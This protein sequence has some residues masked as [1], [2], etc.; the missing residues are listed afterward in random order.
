MGCSCPLTGE[1]PG[2]L[3]V[4][5]ATSTIREISACLF[6]PY[7]SAD[8]LHLGRMIV[9]T[10]VLYIDTPET[11]SEMVI[12]KVGSHR[13]HLLGLVDGLDVRGE[14]FPNLANSNS[15]LLMESSMNL[16]AAIG[17]KSRE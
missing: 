11:L 3:Q 10:R 6:L 5:A 12:G 15:R 9:S 8:I 7:P 2:A 13:L 17:C 16:F 1:Q 14:P 4:R